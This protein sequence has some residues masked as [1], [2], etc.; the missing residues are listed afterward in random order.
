MRVLTTC[1]L[2]LGLAACDGESPPTIDGGV[3]MNVDMAQLYVDDDLAMPP[4]CPQ[5]FESPP[6]CWSGPAGTATPCGACTKVGEECNYFEASLKCAC[7]HQWRCSFA[8]GVSG[9]CQEP[10]GG[11]QCN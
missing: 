4:E 7:D 11:V 3:D 1:L 10:D 9:G 6:Y 2:V 8:G 5:A